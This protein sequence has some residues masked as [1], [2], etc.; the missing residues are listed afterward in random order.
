MTHS[1]LVGDVQEGGGWLSVKITIEKDT[2]IDLRLVSSKDSSLLKDCCC[3][4]VTKS[5]LTLCNPMDYIAHQA[6]LSSSISQS[7][8]K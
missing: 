8:L 1:L 4:S 3:C 6:P 2:W 5:C 7:L